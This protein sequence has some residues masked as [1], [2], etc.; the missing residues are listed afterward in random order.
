MRTP[1]DR[2]LPGPASMVASIFSSVASRSPS[3]QSSLE[4]PIH[5]RT[6]REHWR[7]LV[8][9]KRGLGQGVALLDAAM[10]DV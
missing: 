1:L 7:R 8:P 5:A 9:E 3:R 2:R 6:R 10:L 4:D